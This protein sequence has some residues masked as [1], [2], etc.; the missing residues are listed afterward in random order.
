MPF[1]AYPFVRDATPDIG[2]DLPVIVVLG[3]AWAL[4]SFFLHLFIKSNDR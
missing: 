4:S 3:I 1:A 2:F